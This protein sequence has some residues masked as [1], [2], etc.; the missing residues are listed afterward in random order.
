MP[1]PPSSRQHLID[2]LVA[3]GGAV[4]GEVAADDDERRRHLEPLDPRQHAPQLPH[5]VDA[6][7]SCPG[8][9]RWRSLSCRKT[10][11]TDPGSSGRDGESSR[12]HTQ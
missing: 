4:L 10:I 7:T 8:A 3:L 11:D 12:Q 2:D 1:P 6:A 9:T 5:R